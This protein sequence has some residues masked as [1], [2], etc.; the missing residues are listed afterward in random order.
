MRSTVRHRTIGITGSKLL[1]TAVLAAV[2][3]TATAQAQDL[4]IPDKGYSLEALIEAAKKEGPMVVVDATGKIKTM[5][6][7]FEAKYGIKTTGVKL[8][9]QNQEQVLAREFAADN[10]THD[11]FNMSNLPSV[12]TRFLPEGIGVSWMPPDLVNEVPK[13]YQH[14]AITSLNPWVWAYN[15]SKYGDKCPVQNMWEL[16]EPKWKARSA[17]PTHCCATRRCSGSTR[18][19]PTTTSSCAT[20]IRRNSARH[21]APTSKAQPRNG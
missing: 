3:F 21:S 15:T 10:V 9:G 11:V 14:P 12:T 7:N 16:T 19:K 18:L 2:P 17:F 8:S 20:P 1:L 13:G 6:K 4:G 5:A